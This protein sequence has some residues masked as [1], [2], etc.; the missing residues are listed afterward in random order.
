MSNVDIKVHEANGYVVDYVVPVSAGTG[1]SGLVA[2]DDYLNSRDILL[3]TIAGVHFSLRVNFMAI[4]TRRFELNL[5]IPDRTGDVFGLT[6]GCL[7]AMQ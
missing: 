5:A 4:Q 3:S 2:D 6:L 1:V 7:E